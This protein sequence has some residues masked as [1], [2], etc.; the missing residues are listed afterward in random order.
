MNEKYFNKG[1]MNITGF[2]LLNYTDLEH[3]NENERLQWEWSENNLS[4][5]SQ[6]L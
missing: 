5:S 2:Q 1:G 4:V 3:S 6:A